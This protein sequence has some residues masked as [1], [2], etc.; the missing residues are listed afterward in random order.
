MN[1]IAAIRVMK[2]WETCNRTRFYVMLDSDEGFDMTVVCHSTGSDYT[3]G[4]G[5]SI[6][7]ARDR[8]LIDAHRWGDFLGMEV[9]PFIEDGITYEPSMKMLPYH[10]R[11][12]LAARSA[13]KNT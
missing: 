5:L 13:A 3:D 9:T 11:R 2:T 7:E 6:E 12:V 8:A 1:N 10:T 4:V